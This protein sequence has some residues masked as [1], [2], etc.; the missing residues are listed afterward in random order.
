[1]STYRERREAKAQ[2]LAEWAAKREAKA[3]QAL[4][5]ARGMA[6]AIPFGQPILLGHHSQGRDQRYR[7]RI[8]STYDR[9][10]EHA[11]KAEDMARRAA[12]IES[13]LAGSIY[14][15]D[16]DAIEALQARIAGL[17]AERDRIKA[18]NVSCRKG[19]P[20]ESL[21]TDKDRADLETVK[22]Y[23]PYQLGKGGA[24]PAYKLSNLNGNI[25][26]NRQRL[27]QLSRAAAS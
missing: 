25:T 4:N 5:Q 19:A 26:R 16:P 17:E 20:D 22:R 21:L 9:A 18:Y 13:Q 24:F 11:N 15:D 12:G 8:G 23:A 7:A 27:E 10:F 6:D 2:R 14:S 3:E 1:M